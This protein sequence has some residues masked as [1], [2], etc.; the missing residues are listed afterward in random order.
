MTKAELIQELI[1]NQEVLIEVARND[2]KKHPT[3][4]SCKDMLKER[5]EKLEL[6]K[7][8]K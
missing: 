2:V 3:F 5:M 7:E 6:I 4:E 1:E 8:L